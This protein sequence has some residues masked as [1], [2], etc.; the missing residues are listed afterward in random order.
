MDID[1]A[2]LLG[3]E[4][5][6]DFVELLYTAAK[7]QAQQILFQDRAVARDLLLWLTAV[8]GLICTSGTN[9]DVPAILIA[10]PKA[11]NCPVTMTSCAD[12]LDFCVTCPARVVSAVKQFGKLV[13]AQ[14]SK[15]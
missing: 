12:M 7:R 13:R 1:E 2:D 8:I 11:T 10:L 14:Q 4:P 9:A 3:T 5:A 15:R 6:I